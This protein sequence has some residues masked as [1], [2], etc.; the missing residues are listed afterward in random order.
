MRP[1]ILRINGQNLTKFCI[2]INII[3][4]MCVDIV[5]RHFFAICNRVTIFDSCQ[6][7]FFTQYLENEFTEWGQI[8]Y[9]T[10]H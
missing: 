8:L 1:N 4:K 10:H 5:K 9:T 3:D 6:N 2:N 7:L